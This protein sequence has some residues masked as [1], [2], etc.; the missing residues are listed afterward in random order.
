MSSCALSLVHVDDSTWI[1]ACH[2]SPAAPIHEHNNKHH[3]LAV[4][5]AVNGDD[6]SDCNAVQVRV[7]LDS[8]A[9]LASFPEQSGNDALNATIDN[10]IRA[11]QLDTCACCEAWQR[12]HR[13]Q[14]RGSS[15]IL[16]RL[17]DAPP[18]RLKQLLRVAKSHAAFQQMLQAVQERSEQIAS[19]SKG[20]QQAAA[21]EAADSCCRLCQQCSSA[22]YSLAGWL[23][24]ASV[25]AA[26]LAGIAIYASHPQAVQVGPA[27]H[28]R[29]QS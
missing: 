22:G 12:R 27:M 24:T 3:T 11:L 1:A 23:G 29:Q 4:R 2:A 19:S 6:S 5:Q 8:A 17:A 26:A 28:G 20:W 13:H 16:R 9:H 7:A 18:P 10:L 14:L 21:R 25:S 15:A